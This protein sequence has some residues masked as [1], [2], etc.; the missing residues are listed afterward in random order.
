M[1]IPQP[2]DDDSIP[3]PDVDDSIPQPDVDDSIPQPDVDDDSTFDDNEDQ[4]LENRRCDE[5]LLQTCSCSK[6]HVA[7][8]L[9]CNTTLTSE[10]RHPY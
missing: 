1:S 4:V 3:Q 10:L 5:F 7:V 9:L 6:N 8:C 2:N